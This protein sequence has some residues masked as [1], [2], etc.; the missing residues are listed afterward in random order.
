MKRIIFI[1]ALSFIVLSCDTPNGTPEPENPLV[2]TWVSEDEHVLVR[3]EFTDTTFSYYYKTKSND[4]VSTSAGQY[5]YDEYHVIFLHE[6]ESDS[7]LE[8]T[9]GE[10]LYRIINGNLYISLGIGTRLFIKQ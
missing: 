3:Y 1:L 4:R 6:E 8:I 5:V 2:G 7:L 10:S 9:L